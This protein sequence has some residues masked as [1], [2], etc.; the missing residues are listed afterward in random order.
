MSASSALCHAKLLRA[1]FV[2]VVVAHFR[3]FLEYW[4]CLLEENLA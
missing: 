1:E 4:S 3:V 2:D